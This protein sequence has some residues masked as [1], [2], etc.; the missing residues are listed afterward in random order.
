MF[1]WMIIPNYNSEKWIERGLLS[2]LDQTYTD[3]KITIV[4]DCSTDISPEII[5]QY[6]DRYPDKIRFFP[7]RRRAGF[8]GNV[9][10]AALLSKVDCFG[11][12]KSQYTLFMDSD[13]H[14]ADNYCFE[15]LAKC[16]EENGYPDVIRLPFE[17][18]VSDRE[19]YYIS[20][21]ETSPQEMAVSSYIAPWTKAV[22]TSRLTLFPEDTL[23]EDIPQH[24]AQADVTRNVA[25]CDHKFIIWNRRK[26][27]DVSLTANIDNN[28]EYKRKADASVFKLAAD[29]ILADYNHTYC[30]EMRDS[31]LNFAKQRIRDDK[32]V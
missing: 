1:F 29:L 26:E 28:A 13:D 3:Y 32:L 7:L 14:F 20:F 16:A 27:N 12:E 31:W 8:P 5:K 19:S 17:I 21:S 30:S 25:S 24:L 2:I 4:D 9:R 6:E 15:A 10:N 11:Y 22:K 18:D 23:F